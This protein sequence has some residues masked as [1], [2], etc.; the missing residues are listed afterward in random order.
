WR[1]RQLSIRPCT[2]P[3][4]IA[5]TRCGSTDSNPKENL[6]L[7][8][9]NV[10][11]LRGTRNPIWRAIGVLVGENRRN[12][13]LTHNSRRRALSTIRSIGGLAQD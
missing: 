2:G 1:I 7:E 5:R 12:G 11:S 9:G 3:S 13:T 4:V 10:L 6:I 8:E